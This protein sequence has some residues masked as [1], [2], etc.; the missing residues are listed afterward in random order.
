M[1]GQVTLLVLLLGLGGAPWAH[2]E[3]CDLRPAPLLNDFPS[4]PINVFVPRGRSSG[5]IRLSTQ[6]ADAIGTLTDARGAP[7]GIEVNVLTKFG[8]DAGLALDAFQNLPPNG[9][10]VVQLNDTYASLIAQSGRSNASLVPISLSQIAFSQIYIRTDDTRFSDLSSFVDH[11][12]GRIGDDLVRIA[13]FGTDASRMGLED[14]LLD[15]FAKTHRS[16]LSQDDALPLRQVGYPGAGPRYYSL[17]DETLPEARQTDAL[18]EQPGDVAGLI[19]SGLLKPIFTLLPQDDLTPD[20]AARLGDTEGFPGGAADGCPMQYRFRGFFVPEGVPPDRR[21]VLEWIFT[22]AFDTPGF[23]SIN[24]ANFIDLLYPDDAMQAAYCS[25]DAARAFFDER[26]DTYASCFR[27]REVG[28]EQ[29]VS[30]I[31]DE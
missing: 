15:R 11:A 27:Q 25:A 5:A 7:L 31:G 9:Y 26:I 3:L 12:A 1:A 8:G 2:A 19:N 24:R 20:L 10:N 28:Q 23:Q 17:F 18:L 22:A 13:K 29:A 21:R 6:I 14:I 16:G 30:G 4:Q